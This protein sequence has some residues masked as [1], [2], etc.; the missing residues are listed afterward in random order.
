MT[1]FFSRSSDDRPDATLTRAGGNQLSAAHYEEVSTHTPP[2]CPILDV[3]GCHPLPHG[4]CHGVARCP[5]VGEAGAQSDFD[6][7]PHDVEQEFAVG[8]GDVVTTLL[9]PAL[10]PSL[11]P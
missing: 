9:D 7:S 3:P 2:C 5:G 11:R 8:S 4:G 1:K 6:A 10:R